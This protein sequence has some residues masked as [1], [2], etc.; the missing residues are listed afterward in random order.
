MATDRLCGLV[1]RIPG[2][3]SRDPGFD[4]WRNQIFWEVVGLEQGP[5][6]LMCTIEELL[7]R[8]SSGS[9]LEKR[10][11]DRGDPLRWPHDT[12]YPQQLALTLPTSGGCLVCIVR[13]WTE[14]TEFSFFLICGN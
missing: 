14:A 3:R 13:S 7:R 9:G 1:V 2:Y 10:E 12:L 5:L 8:N 11:Y 6:S 4:F